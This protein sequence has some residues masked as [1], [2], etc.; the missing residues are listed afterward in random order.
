MQTVS[1]ELRD[2]VDARIEQCR[3]MI[4]ESYM[5]NNAPTPT[6]L[7][8][9]NSARTAGYALDDTHIRIN[10][11]FLNHNTEYY[12]KQVVGHEYAH[13]A[14]HRIYGPGSGHGP[15]WKQ[16]MWVLG[17]PAERLHNMDLPDGV[18][19]GK[20]KP[21]FGYHCGHCQAPVPVGPT[22]HK[23]IQKGATYWH[24]PCGRGKGDLVF[25]K[26]LGN[27]NSSQAKRALKEAS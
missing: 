21:K 23:K 15:R 3:Q 16:A 19:V 24:T 14:A 12:I 18:K 2:R 25:A 9:I 5:I 27:L 26:P 13:C 7:Y 8:N 11:A 22:V 6:I 20:P 17:L 10:P 1:K 4:N